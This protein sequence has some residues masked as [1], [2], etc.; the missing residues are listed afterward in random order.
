M[1]RMKDLFGDEPAPPVSEHDLRGMV[2][3]PD[4]STS[5]EAARGVTEIKRTLQKRVYELLTIRPRTDGELETLPEFSDYRYS[6]VR[7]R[8]SELYQDGLLVWT[9][10]KRAG[11]KVWKAVTRSPT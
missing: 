4:H 11:Q 7:K 6:T 9:G 1:S 8:R 3:V 10:E 5:I 2:R